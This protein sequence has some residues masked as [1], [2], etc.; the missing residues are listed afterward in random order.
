MDPENAIPPLDPAVGAVVN[1]PEAVVGSVVERVR[2]V[3]KPLAVG[4][5]RVDAR[6]LMLRREVERLTWRLDMLMRFLSDEHG[7]VF[8][9]TWA[10]PTMLTTDAGVPIDDEPA[11]DDTGNPTPVIPVVRVSAVK[12]EPPPPPHEHVW[13]PRVPWPVPGHPDVARGYQ[14]CDC[15]FTREVP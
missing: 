5:D 4:L 11:D 9:A 1:D 13:G 7:L 15:G 2:T 12:I 6:V 10:P 14:R 3:A 8:P